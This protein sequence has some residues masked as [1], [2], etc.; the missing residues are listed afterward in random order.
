MLHQAFR[1]YVWSNHWTMNPHALCLLIKKED[2][3]HMWCNF[4]L[5]FICNFCNTRWARL[6]YFCSIERNRTVFLSKRTYQSE[7]FC[8][9]SPLFV[10]FSWKSYDVV[11]FRFLWY[12]EGLN[13]T[14]FYCVVGRN[15]TERDYSMKYKHV[16][17]S[18]IRLVVK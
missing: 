14:V 6:L 15:G 7:D 18:D 12:L 4:Y 10:S 16:F 11:E 8:C 3:H 1:C 5:T 2:I 13:I 17:V 9:F